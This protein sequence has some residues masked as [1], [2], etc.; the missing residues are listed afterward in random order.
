MARKSKVHLSLLRL[1][2]NFISFP[3]EKGETK[4]KQQYQMKTNSYIYETVKTFTLDLNL[5]SKGV[6]AARSLPFHSLRPS[7]PIPKTRKDFFQTILEK[8]FEFVQWVRI[9]LLD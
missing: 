3:I 7:L 6:L 9:G 1:V 5:Y 8:H 2:Y 4:S